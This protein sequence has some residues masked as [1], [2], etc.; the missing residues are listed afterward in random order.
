MPPRRVWDFEDIPIIS[1]R[2]SAVIMIGILAIITLA[3][4]IIVS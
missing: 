4:I 2:M 3:V 1:P